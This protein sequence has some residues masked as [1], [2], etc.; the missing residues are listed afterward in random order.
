ML[1]ARLA[2]PYQLICVTADGWYVQGN[3]ADYA[4]AL[5]D[6]KGFTKLRPGKTYYVAKGDP[7]SMIFAKDQPEE[8]TPA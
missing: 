1:Q 8:Y 3:Y 5:R 6:A 7:M 2:N 4:P